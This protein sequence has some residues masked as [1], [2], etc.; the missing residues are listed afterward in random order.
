MI[1]AKMYCQNVQDHGDNEQVTL[2]AVADDANKSWAKWT[3]SG[4]A[5]LTINNEDAKGKFEKGKTY[6]V[7]FSPAPATEAGE[8]KAGGG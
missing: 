5:T 8:A 4:G 7:D 6:F 1:R 3:P 2:S